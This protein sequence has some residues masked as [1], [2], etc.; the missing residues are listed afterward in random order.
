MHPIEDLP[1]LLPEA[2]VLVLVLPQTPQTQGLIGAAELALLPDGALVVNVG[3][4]PALDTATPTTP[5][6]IGRTAAHIDR[7]ITNSSA[8]AAMTPSPSGPCEPPGCT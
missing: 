6:R 3:R 1:A 7:N 2:D 8:N 5:V 4:G